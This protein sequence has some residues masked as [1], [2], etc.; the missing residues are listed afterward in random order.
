MIYFMFK[1]PI[2]L[3]KYNNKHNMYLMINFILY[4]IHCTLTS[5]CTSSYVDALSIILVETA[6]YIVTV[7]LA[8]HVAAQRK[9][10]KYTKLYL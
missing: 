5:N 4:H 2:L 8:L 10:N 1:F 9:L 7:T 6:S 3:Q